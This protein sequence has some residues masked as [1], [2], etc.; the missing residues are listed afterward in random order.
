MS[1]QHI[2]KECNERNQWIKDIKTVLSPLFVE[3][4][5]LRKV[6]WKTAQNEGI[7][8]LKFS[9]YEKGIVIWQDNNFSLEG[10]E[11]LLKTFAFYPHIYYR[12]HENYYGLLSGISRLQGMRIRSSPIYLYVGDLLDTFYM[13]VMS[14]KYSHRNQQLSLN[15]LVLDPLLQRINSGYNSFHI[16]PFVSLE[17]ACVYSALKNFFGL[18]FE[19]ER[20]TRQDS[21]LILEKV[22]SLVKKAIAVVGATKTLRNATRFYNIASLYLDSSINS[23]LPKMRELL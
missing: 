12:N 13:S 21:R 22:E 18:E 20:P 15:E 1:V 3:F 16:N 6:I 23:L 17:S 5:E 19:V 8:P 11:E 2:Y 14:A 4:G 10:Y 7:L 9:Q